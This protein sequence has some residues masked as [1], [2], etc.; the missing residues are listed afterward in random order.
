VLFALAKWPKPKV[1]APNGR[2]KN[3][4][5]FTIFIDFEKKGCRKDTCNPLI[6]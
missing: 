3:F 4:L 6:N 2:Y 1:A 5:L